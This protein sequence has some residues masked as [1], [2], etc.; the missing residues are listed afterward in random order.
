[1]TGVQ[2]I[3]RKGV[4][5][6]FETFE[7]DTW[8]LYQG[9]QFIV[10]GVGADSLDKWLTGFE[11]S[12]STATY[13]LRV[14]DSEEAPTS[15]TGNSDYVACIAFKALDP[16]DGYGIN[17]H[18]N[19]LLDRIGALEKKLEKGDDDEE[20]TDLNS[21]IM[22]WLSDP[23]KLGQVAGAIR[24]VFG[25]AGAI[26]PVALPAA[27]VQTISG[28]G[29]TKDE[30]TANT[31]EEKL[32]RLAAALDILEKKDPDLVSHMEKLAKLSQTQPGLFKTVLMQL[33]SL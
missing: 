25:G 14:Y 17:G 24:T 9:K 21:I 33:D 23:V 18:N 12:G 5:E 22:G 19:K 31:T 16:Y 7:T 32:Q 3:G 30:P 2:L 4:L 27:P 20:I 15:A 10:G 13:M 8:A 29:V 1:M 11:Q 6:R 28:F 26:Q